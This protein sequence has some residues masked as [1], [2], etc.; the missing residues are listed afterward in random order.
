MIF[1]DFPLTWTSQ[2]VCRWVCSCMGPTSSLSSITKP[3]CSTASTTRAADSTAISLISGEVLVEGHHENHHGEMRPTSQHHP[4][5]QW[6][7]LMHLDPWKTCALPSW[8]QHESQH[9][10][11]LLHSSIFSA[12]G[13]FHDD[14][15]HVSQVTFSRIC[16]GQSASKELRRNMG[17]IMI[18][19]YNS[20]THGIP[21]SVKA[22][23]HC[24]TAQTTRRPKQKRPNSRHTKEQGT[25]HPAW[26]W[27]WHAMGYGY[28]RPGHGAPHSCRVRLPG[29][30]VLVPGIVASEL[31]HSSL[32][33]YTWH[34]YPTRLQFCPLR[35][36]RWSQFV[37]NCWEHSPWNHIWKLLT[38]GVSRVPDAT[39]FHYLSSLASACNAPH[40][41]TTQQVTHTNKQSTPGCFFM[42]CSKP[43]KKSSPSCPA[44]PGVDER[45]KWQ[46]LGTVAPSLRHQCRVSKFVNCALASLECWSLLAQETITV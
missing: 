34:T 32:T 33:E 1:H 27:L 11:N 3:F 14:W 7:H 36:W 38:K 23:E 12:T 39:W 25:S 37:K 24:G 19:M 15:Q 46:A 44:L 26:S 29:T 16:S 4:R 10:Q 9:R 8:N 6:A 41:C 17:V 40:I 43:C 13:N 35:L 31:S 22:S 5:I 2:H 20:T 30:R 21:L 45:H 28:K 18:I 42:S